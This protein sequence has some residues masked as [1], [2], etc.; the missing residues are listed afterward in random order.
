MVVENAF[1]RFFLYAA[2]GIFFEVCVMAI[3]DIITK[4][5]D[6]SKKWSLM[7]RSYLWMIPVYG[8]LL[9][10]PFEAILILLLKIPINKYIILFPIAFPIWGA[11]FILFEAFT[12]WIINLIIGYPLWDKFPKD[13]G[14]ILGGYTSWPLIFVWGIVGIMYSFITLKLWTLMG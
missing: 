8:L 10:F 5:V 11:L 13:K 9:L 12:G 4:K 7:G 3:S 1:F 14:G 6:P 2:I